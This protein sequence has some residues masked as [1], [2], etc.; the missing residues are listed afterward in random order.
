MKHSITDSIVPEKVLKARLCASNIELSE[1]EFE[2][3]TCQ[4]RKEKLVSVHLLQ[5]EEKVK[6]LQHVSQ[7]D[8][9]SFP[10][11]SSLQRI[12]R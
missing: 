10:N 11:N 6:S 3:V 5:N 9:Q 1:K 8:N 2:I 4:L 12:F 7:N